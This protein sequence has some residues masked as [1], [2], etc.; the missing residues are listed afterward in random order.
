[1]NHSLLRSIREIVRL[2]ISESSLTEADTYTKKFGKRFPLYKEFEKHV[3]EKKDGICNYA[4]T[5]TSV[6]KVGINPRSKYE[7][8]AGIYFYPL[9]KKN[10]D[11]LLDWNLPFVSDAKYVSLV[12]LKKPSKWLDVTRE[13]NEYQSVL[14]LILE[15]VYTFLTDEWRQKTIKDHSPSNARKQKITHDQHEDHSNKE[16][17]DWVVKFFGKNQ[18]SHSNNIASKI[19]DY[20]YFASRYSKNPQATWS[21]ILT[22]AGI[23]GIY[24]DGGGVIHANEPSQLVAFRREYVEVIGTY[25]TSSIIKSTQEISDKIPDRILYSKIFNEKSVEKLKKL[26][27]LYKNSENTLLLQQFATNKATPTEILEELSY[28]SNMFLAAQVAKNRK[29]SKEA[30]D[31]LVSHKHEMVRFA[32]LNN[33]KT[34]KETLKKLESDQSWAISAKAK[35]KLFNKL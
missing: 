20:A 28:A 32:V 19:F 23:H 21:R 22:E 2:S 10:Y 16:V 12:K 25:E 29:T 31:R 14:D 24:D 35:E 7:T 26:Y 6:E 27:D 1:M 18:L 17:L 3:D 8:P 15:N 30:L 34:S 11:N 5:M 4:F 9:T 33:P 13:S